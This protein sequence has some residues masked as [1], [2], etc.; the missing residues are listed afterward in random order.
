M[1]ITFADALASLYPT[2][3]WSMTDVTVYSTLTWTDTNT[4]RPSEEALQTEITNLTVQEPLTKCSNEAKIRIAASD[5]SVLP[6]V[7][8][9]NKSDFEAYR[10]A[11]RTFI[12]TPVVDP[13]F[14]TEPQP[15]W[16]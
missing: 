7:N 15:I 16:I 10:A 14:P 4:S 9:S 5:W 2:A 12:I 8:I 1:S 13:V 6:D 11:L 3:Q